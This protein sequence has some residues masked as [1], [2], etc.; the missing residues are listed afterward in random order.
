MKT[1]KEKCLFSINV[2]RLSVSRAKAVAR[3]YMLS[4]KPSRAILAANTNVALS[5][6]TIGVKIM[7][8]Y[9]KK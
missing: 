4:M 8:I 7:Q 5:Y 9:V 3:K 2:A 6:E 1:A